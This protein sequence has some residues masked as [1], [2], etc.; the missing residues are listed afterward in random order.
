MHIQPY[1]RVSRWERTTR[2][3]GNLPL[4]SNFSLLLSRFSSYLCS[5]LFCVF[6]LS[7]LF[8]TSTIAPSLA[9]SLALARCSLKERALSS[10]LLVL[11]VSTLLP[12]FPHRERKLFIVNTRGLDIPRPEP[13]KQ[14]S[15]QAT[16]L[17]QREANFLF[18]FLLYHDDEF[19]P[20]KGS[21]LSLSFSL[22]TF[23]SA[24]G[25]DPATK[26][27]DLLSYFGES[28]RC[29]ERGVVAP[30]SRGNSEM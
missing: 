12:G 22:L 25:N 13:T 16:N 18:F 24:A 30:R 2:F 27:D 21:F 19:P 26:V 7:L 4:L 8:A 15:K 5:C 17:N 10:A 28:Y 11:R 29:G 3:H 20:T 23:L 1:P 14:A 9:T 6:S